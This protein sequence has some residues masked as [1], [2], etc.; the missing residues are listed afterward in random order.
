[1]ASVTGHERS[2]KDCPEYEV[3]AVRVAP[4]TSG[5]RARTE[6]AESAAD[7]RVG[8]LPPY[9][10]LVNA[11]AVQFAHRTANEAVAEVVTHVRTFWDPRVRRDL[12]ACVDRGAHGLHP[13]AVRAAE[14][15]RK[16]G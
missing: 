7:P 6:C 2:P 15:L 3:A 8:P 1:M 16:N 9:L 10:R 14:L 12:F 11:I 5:A 4:P 13:I